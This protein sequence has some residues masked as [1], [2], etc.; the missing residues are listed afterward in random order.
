MF[1]GVHCFPHI[2]LHN[3]GFCLE[4]KASK[5]NDE[6]IGIEKVKDEDIDIKERTED[7]T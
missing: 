1:W 5:S 7:S 6:E 4:S 2:I 3:A